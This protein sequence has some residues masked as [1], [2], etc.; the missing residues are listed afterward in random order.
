MAGLQGAVEKA[1]R[2]LPM[3]GF[4]VPDASSAIYERDAECANTPEPAAVGL[5]RVGDIRLLS[6]TPTR[7]HC[8]SN[9]VC[10][11]LLTPPNESESRCQASARAVRH[12]GGTECSE[13]AVSRTWPYL[14]YIAHQVAVHRI[15]FP[16]IAFEL[17]AQCS[18]RIPF[19]AC[20]C[21]R[22]T[23]NGRCT[24]A[25]FQTGVLHVAR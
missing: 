25:R 8:T 4:R 10:C 19:C 12:C 14:G 13:H 17:F 18:Q 7:A 9:G 11:S 20:H 23:V 21:S 16:L 5:A 3:P 1:P 24:I 22:R 6:L 15:A 2:H